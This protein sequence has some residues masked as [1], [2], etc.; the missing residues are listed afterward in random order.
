MTTA[1]PYRGQNAN[2]H[3]AEALIALYEATGE[4]RHLSRAASIAPKTVELAQGCGWVIE[5]Y[6]ASW[7]ADPHKNRDADP[8][9]EEY[10]FRPPG[11]QPSL[12]APWAATES[13][14]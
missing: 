14:A 5:H 13:R 8:S 2:M 10:I 3:M 9:S 7:A 1:N 4:V 12:Q 6:D 11:F